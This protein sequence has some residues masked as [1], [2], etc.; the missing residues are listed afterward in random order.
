MDEWLYV[1]QPGDSLWTITRRYL[2]DGLRYWRPLIRHNHVEKPRRMPPG[3]IIRIPARWLRIVPSKARIEQLS[4]KVWIDGPGGV[5]RAERGAEI[6]GGETVRA[7]PDSTVLIRLANGS[8]ILLAA[9]SAIRFDAL[10]GYANTLMVDASV[11]LMAGRIE[12]RMKR[13]GSLDRLKIRGPVAV[14]AV[15]G[16]RFRVATRGVA[17]RVEVLKGRLT[18]SAAG[19]SRAV[20]G[21]WGT[22][23]HAGEAPKPP[24]KL[25][26]AP[27]IAEGNL[28]LDRLPLEIEVR[29]VAGASGYRVQVAPDDRFD[30]LLIDRIGRGPR[31]SL[32]SLDDGSYALRL[33]AIDPDGIEGKD[34][35]TTIEVDARPVP[36]FLIA[37]PHQGRMHQQPPEFRWTGVEGAAGYRF[38]LEGEAGSRLAADLPAVDHFRPPQTLAPGNYRWRIATVDAGGER[39]PFSDPQSFRQ[40]PPT[41]RIGGPAQ[42]E[43]SEEGISLRWRDAGASYRYHVQASYDRRFRKP[44]LDRLVRG[45]GITLRPGPAREVFVRIAIVEPDGYEGGFGP[46]QRIALPPPSWWPLLLL[47]F[48]LPWFL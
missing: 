46:V 4:G 23:A 5:R 25:L 20:L 39:G 10:S 15:R 35:Q 32:G 36:P 16:T 34:F 33:R 27:E 22:L 48:L 29:P 2:K 8:D 21:G 28:R 17:D 13:Q 7:G 6:R 31:L 12:T 26:P 38:E 37:P 47:P 41:P 3:T 18:F 40:L 24:R 42:V 1:V 9:G 11:R 44:F 14:S 30:R 45:N 43:A 19:R